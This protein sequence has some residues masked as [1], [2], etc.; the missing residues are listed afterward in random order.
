MTGLLKELGPE[1]AD[2]LYVYTMNVNY[3]PATARAYRI[4][5]VPTVILFNNGRPVEAIRGLIPLQPLR[6]KLAKLLAD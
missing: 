4:Q 1:F 3:N 2:R 6:E 5:T